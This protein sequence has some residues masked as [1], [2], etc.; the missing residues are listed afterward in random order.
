MSSLEQKTAGPPGLWKR[1]D[2]PSPVN[3]CPSP[4]A[5]PSANFQFP[6]PTQ[7]LPVP[8][9][10]GD[11]H[12][13]PLP[14]PAYSGGVHRRPLPEPADPGGV[15]R[16]PMPAPAY[17]GGIHRQPLPA[18]A[19]PGGV[20]R[21]PLPAPADPGGV[22][23]QPLPAPATIGGVLRR[24]LPDSGNPRRRSP[25]AP[26]GTIYGAFSRQKRHFTTIYGGR[27]PFRGFTASNTHFPTVKTK[28]MQ[29]TIHKT[30][31]L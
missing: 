17:P 3:Y 18:P 2:K 24:P 15:Y 14:A 5:S 23:R 28:T 31:N 12:R 20:P 22:L 27:Q 4:S 9:T 8:A 7:L 30:T 11:V 19:D 26:A 1:P 13:Q 25:A 16:R 21:R 29:L 10:Y 6:I